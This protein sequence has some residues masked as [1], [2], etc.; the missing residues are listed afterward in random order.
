MFEGGKVKR[1]MY[2]VL[3]SAK[4]LLKLGN[5]A[6]TVVMISSNDGDKRAS[7]SAVNAFRNKKVLPAPVFYAMVHPKPP[8]KP[9]AAAAPDSKPLP[10]FPS[11]LR[12]LQRPSLPPLTLTSQ[13]NP[14]ILPLRSPL[15]PTPPAS[16]FK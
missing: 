6:A 9:S 11:S 16:R 1:G 2:K 15:T 12:S 10:T 5:K 13:L 3:S 14:S 7:G 8:S 4:A